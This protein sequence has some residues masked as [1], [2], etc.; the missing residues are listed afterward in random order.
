M[1]NQAKTKLFELVRSLSMSE[2]RF[3]KIFSA[4][5]TIGEK[6]NYI[7]L[8]D[9]ID[10]MDV[11]D[12]EAVRKAT[13]VKNAAAEKNYLY[14]IILK[15][16]NVFH[17]QSTTRLKVYDLLSSAEILKQKGLYDQSLTVVLKALQ[18]AQESELL[19]E[20]LMVQEMQEELLLKSLDYGQTLEVFN[21]DSE[22][23]ERIQNLKEMSALTTKAYDE[24]LSRGVVRQKD[25]LATLDGVLNSP[26]MR[27]EQQALT[28]RA[29]LHQISLALTYN[30]VA[31]DGEALLKEAHRITEH[32]EAHPN[33]IEYTPVGY[34]SAL[35]ILGMGQR[36]TGRWKEGLKT[37]EKLGEVAGLAAVKKSQ[38]AVASGFFYQ[39]ILGLQLRLKLS[40]FEGSAALVDEI[41]G[42]V[43]AF[44]PFIGKPQL[45]DLNFQ[46]CKVFFIHQDYKSALKYTNEILNDTQFKDRDDFQ[47]TV[48]LFNLLVHFELGNDFTLDYLSRSTHGYL[49]KRN[50][51]FKVEKVLVRFIEKY[52]DNERAAEAKDA[53]IALRKE[54]K[55]CAEHEYE[56]RALRHFDFGTWVES[57]LLEKGLMEVYEER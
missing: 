51:L 30:M 17:A 7:Q 16:L 34:V 33:L 35:F 55:E 39:H 14:R 27:D 41:R 15:S 46:F 12:D 50:K 4:R 56:Q 31:G 57:K 40:D 8:F 42:K 22:L 52:P 48:R 38:K 45:Y 26:L 1:A 37:V 11:F 2:K 36:D 10:R 54:L 21:A 25:D 23:L 5:H 13:F 47:I 24:N 18:L 3:F 9:L 43:D 19:R 49:K 28:S 6:N 44:A 32:Y 53:L 20:Q 29:R